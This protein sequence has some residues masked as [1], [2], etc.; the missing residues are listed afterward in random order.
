MVRTP[1]FH[2]RGPGFHKPRS[3]A[4]KKKKIGKIHIRSE[5]DTITGKIFIY[6]LSGFEIYII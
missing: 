2:C 6:I 4:K 5:P 1:F 3:A